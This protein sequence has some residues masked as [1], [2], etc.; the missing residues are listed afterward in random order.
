MFHV[1]HLIIVIGLLLVGIVVST[2]DLS[3]FINQPLVERLFYIM[4]LFPLSKAY[5]FE[6]LGMG[7]F[8]VMIQLFFTEKLL[9][10]QFQPIHNVFLLIFS[11]LGIVGLSLFLGFLV[12]VFWKNQNNVPRGTLKTKTTQCSTWNIENQNHS[13]FHVEHS[14]YI[15]KGEDT[16]TNR[17]VILISLCQ[18]LLIMVMIIMLVDHYWWDIQQGQLLLWIIL[19]LMVVRKY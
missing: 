10:W 5:F 2:F 18:S 15:D 12:Y 9:V 14:S 8:V 7:Q 11:E 19:G 16:E 4:P 13:M 17:K 6:G 1:E 3:L